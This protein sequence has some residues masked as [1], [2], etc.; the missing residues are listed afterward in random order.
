MEVGWRGQ[1]WVQEDRS[2]AIIT[3]WYRGNDKV[4]ADHLPALPAGTR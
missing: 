2:R 1:A 3:G 4:H